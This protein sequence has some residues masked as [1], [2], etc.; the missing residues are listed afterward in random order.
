MQRRLSLSGR[1]SPGSIWTENFS[2]AWFIHCFGDESLNHALE[3]IIS[4]PN[5]AAARLVDFWKESR[6]KRHESNSPCIYGERPS[7]T[8]R[9]CVH[10]PYSNHALWSANSIGK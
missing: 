10:F 2:Q 4:S 3:V 9:A 8:E 6:V 5:Y 7:L 1:S